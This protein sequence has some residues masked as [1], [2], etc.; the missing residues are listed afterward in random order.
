MN[1]ET[2]MKV[3]MITKIDIIHMKMMKVTKTKIHNG[4]NLTILI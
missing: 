1:K 2:T 4:N 3:Q